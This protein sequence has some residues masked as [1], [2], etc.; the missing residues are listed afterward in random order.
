MTRHV[1]M[2][3]SDTLLALSCMCTGKKGIDLVELVAR[4]QLCESL[5]TADT[6]IHPT[7]QQPIGSNW[8]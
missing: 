4:L 5:M 7:V 1:Y 8:L 2:A 3:P 6:E